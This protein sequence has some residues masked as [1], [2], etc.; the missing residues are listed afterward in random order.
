MNQLQWKQGQQPVDQRVSI[1]AEDSIAGTFCAPVID[2]S[3]PEDE[4]SDQFRSFVSEYLPH[5]VASDRELTKLG[6]TVPTPPY[7]LNRS[8]PLFEQLK[9]TGSA[10]EHDVT[11]TLRRDQTVVKTFA[12]SFETPFKDPSELEGQLHPIL[13]P[14]RMNQA[15][16]QQIEDRDGRPIN[17]QTEPD[18]SKPRSAAQ[19]QQGGQQSN[20]VTRERPRL[21]PPFEGGGEEVKGL[22]TPLT[23]GASEG[24]GQPGGSSSDP[25]HPPTPSI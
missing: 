10:L 5:K 23:G 6:H 17:L 13:N 21:A 2:P 18:P 22:P 12:R 11:F 14:D 9:M 15:T 8:V 4:I 16:L 7:D 20:P 24:G 1:V 25:A 3:M 19:G